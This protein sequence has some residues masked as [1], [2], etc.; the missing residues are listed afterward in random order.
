MV[1]IIT[2]CIDHTHNMKLLEC[3]SNEEIW[4]AVNN[5]GALKAPELDG[6]CAAF[7]QGC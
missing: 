7:Y 1:D 5:I 4:E 2:P 3:I 6:L